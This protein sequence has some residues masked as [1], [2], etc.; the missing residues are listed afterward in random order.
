[1]FDIVKALEVFA[2]TAVVDVVWARYVRHIA[3][4]RAVPAALY[5]TAIALIGGFVTL[6]YVGDPVMLLPMSL[7]A[8]FGTWLAVRFGTRVIP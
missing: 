4:S 2:A 6:T 7:G 8:C 5:A 3:D 1:M